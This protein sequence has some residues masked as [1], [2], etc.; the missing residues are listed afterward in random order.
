MLA[1]T[2]LLKL[3]VFGMREKERC[4]VVFLTLKPEFASMSLNNH[5]CCVEPKYPNR[6][7]RSVLRW[8]R[9]RTCRK[10]WAAQ[11]PWYTDTLVFD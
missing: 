10:S 2:L 7:R 4:S 3:V 1:T 5:F 11:L 9:D 6:S 8:L